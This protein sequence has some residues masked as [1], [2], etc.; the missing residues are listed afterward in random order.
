[1]TTTPK[2]IQI[3]LPSGEPHGIRIAEITTRI[4][5]VIEVPRSLLSSFLAM[6]Q[7]SQVGVYF[8]IGEGGED[9]ERLVYVG[10]SGDLRARLTTH[11]QTKD[12]WERALVLV[13]KTNSLTQTHALFLEWHALQQ[14]RSAG[15][16][17]DENGNSGSRP[18]TPAPLEAECLEVFETGSILF[19]SLGYP[20]F[21][22][23]SKLKQGNTPEPY[24]YLRSPSAGVEGKGL[25]TAEG[26]VV[27]AGSIGRLSN[28]PSIGESNARWRQRLLDAGV[29][30]P[31]DEG[32]LVFPKDHLFKAPSGAAIA[33]LGRRANGWMEWKSDKGQTLH[34]LIREPEVSNP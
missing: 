18:H 14:I 10:Q 27:L 2:T 24:F 15:R 11:N 7:S 33:L 22:A 31:D 16:F 4:V 29:M 9:E 32:G 20:L 28:A 5:Q 3:F 25:Y 6:E 13:S 8:L 23:L 26:F 30:Q 19:S 34:Q 21:D 1:M 12:F 17:A